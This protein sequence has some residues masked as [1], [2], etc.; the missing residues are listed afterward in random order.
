M[1]LSS[2]FPSPYISLEA[3]HDVWFQLDEPV[4]VAFA[5]TT[6]L[7]KDF[8]RKV[9]Y[10]ADVLANSV[11]VKFIVVTVELENELDLVTDWKINRYPTLLIYDGSEVVRLSEDIGRDELVQWV[12]HNLEVAR[13]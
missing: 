5:G 1:A 13:A 7:A 12:R 3:L 9:E 4:V 10:A 8:M 6:Q 11:G 2:W